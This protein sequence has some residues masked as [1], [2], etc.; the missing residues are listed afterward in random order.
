MGGLS[1]ELLAALQTSVSG[2]AGSFRIEYATPVAGGCIHRCFVLE[3]GGRRYFAKTNDS[4]TLDSFAAE[5]DGLA[6]LAAAGA[7]VPA[8][9]CRGQGGKEA[10]LVL[11][12]LNLRETGDH[13]ALGH[14]LA[15]MHTVHGENYGWRRDNYIGRT[16]QLNRC[17]GSW[18]DFWRD[19]RLV[20]QLKFARK[21]GLGMSLLRKG[22]RLVVALPLLLSGKPAA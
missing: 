6:A 1:G 9:L 4:S 22:E 20:P 18:S 8:P 10:F 2:A 17:S 13:A 21:N 15:V 3:G 14:E 7:R 16:P 11:E 5:A 19:A 12:Y